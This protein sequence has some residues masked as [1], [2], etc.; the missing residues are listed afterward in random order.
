M[1]MKKIGFL[2]LILLSAVF[3][4]PKNA[5]CD[6]CGSYNESSCFY[7]TDDCAIYFAGDY[8]GHYSDGERASC[9]GG[10]DRAALDVKI[11][12]YIND[13]LRDSECY[14]SFG[15]CRETD[16]DTVHVGDRVHCMIMDGDSGGIC[17]LG[18]PLVPGCTIPGVSCHL[19][20]VEIVG[21]CVSTETPES[22][23]NDGKDNDCD[24]DTDCD[25]SDCA[26]DPACAAGP[27]PETICNDGAD[28]DGD[29]DTDC[30][31]S[32]C[33]ADPACAAGP[34]PETICNDGA[35]N[36]GDGDTD[37]D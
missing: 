35:D 14:T 22:T 1:K 25:D 29:G 18:C 27:G 9:R 24:G 12:L 15:G 17:S 26:A 3:A 8:G 5:S 37:C 7:A 31:D 21:A 36:D 20:S 10:T 33:A 28:N 13:A 23:C 2:L 11:C 32:D 30:D 34:G 6:Q 16:E 19:M 4:M